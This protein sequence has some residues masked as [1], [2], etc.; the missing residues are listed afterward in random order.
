MTS[1][2]IDTRLQE[3]GISIPQA[4]IPAANYVPYVQTGNT[5]FI[6][7]QLPLQGSEVTQ[8]GQLGAGVSIEQGQ[9]CARI[10]ALNVI[11]Q[12]KHA[13]GGDLSR[14]KRIVKLCVFVNSTPTFTDQPQVA[15]GASDLFVNIFGDAGKH[16]RSAVG[17]SQ[18]PRNAAVEVE[19]VVEIEQ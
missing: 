17:V 18:L 8:T 11:A 6:S 14:V 4:S 15:N 19:A 16:A 7:G 10:C 12:V 9:A 13:L 3:L 1:L 2:A 5:L